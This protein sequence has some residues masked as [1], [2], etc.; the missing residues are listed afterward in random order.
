VLPL[1]GIDVIEHVR[2]PTRSQSRAAHSYVIPSKA[3]D[4]T[5][6]QHAPRTGEVLRCA[7]DN[8]AAIA[9]PITR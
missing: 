3:R 6:A 1:L 4:L 8:I 9:M 2:L 7:Q 5:N